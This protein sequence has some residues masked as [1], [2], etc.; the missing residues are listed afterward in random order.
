MLALSSRLWIA[1]N[2]RGR[3]QVAPIIYETADF[4]CSFSSKKC[5]R[6]VAVMAQNTMCVFSIPTLTSGK[7]FN[8]K[9]MDL[10]YTL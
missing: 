6:G 9:S 1:F 7:V 4:G 3:Y 2:L 8:S 10:D 5:T